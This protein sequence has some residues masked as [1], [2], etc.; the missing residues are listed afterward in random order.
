M[1]GDE[2]VYEDEIAEESTAVSSESSAKQQSINTYDTDD[3]AQFPSSEFVIVTS[4]HAAS[5]QRTQLPAEIAASSR[6]CSLQQRL[7]L[8][9]EIAASSRDCSLQ[10]RLKL[11]AEIE[12]YS[13]D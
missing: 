13:R 4:Q 9:A 8:A 12:A 1:V 10:Q 6:D 3:G 2:T 7:Q 11:T 5:S